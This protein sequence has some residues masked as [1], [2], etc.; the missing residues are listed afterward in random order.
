MLAKWIYFG[1]VDDVYKE[2]MI[3]EEKDIEKKN[4]TKKFKDNF[5][6]KKFTLRTE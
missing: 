3:A 6:D 2:F 1:V 5:W 4:L